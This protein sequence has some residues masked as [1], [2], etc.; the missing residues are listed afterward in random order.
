MAMSEEKIREF[1]LA[2]SKAAEEL[3]PFWRTIR[4]EFPETETSAVVELGEA[5]ISMNKIR[6]RIYRMIPELQPENWS[7][8]PVGKKDNG[9][10]I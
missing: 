4:D 10:D 5:I 3:D 1:E 8:N 2:L 6:S 9:K 7:G